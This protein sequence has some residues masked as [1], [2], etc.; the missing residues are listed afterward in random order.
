MI[1]S[2]GQSLSETHPLNVDVCR[3]NKPGKDL[4][5]G[6]SIL[7]EGQLV[8]HTPPYGSDVILYDPVSGWE[9]SGTGR[10]CAPKVHSF[11]EPVHGRACLIRPEWMDNHLDVL[12][13]SSGSG[14]RR[15]SDFGQLRCEHRREHGDAQ[16]S[17]R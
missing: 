11:G 3:I 2:F 16:P 9:V 5:Y 6:Q 15:E 12:G 10:I 8:F 4:G 1:S 14:C 17:R 13:H 7:H